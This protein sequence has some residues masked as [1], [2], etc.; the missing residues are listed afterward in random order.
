MSISLYNY[1]IIVPL[2]I[3]GL[4]STA[5]CSND[6]IDPSKA[7]GGRPKMMRAEG[8]VV[9]PQV[10]RQQ[11]TASG[12][13]LP[14]E[15]VALHPEISGRVTAI[16]FREGSQ[17]RKGQLL[18]QLYDAD[19]KAQIQKLRAQRALQA[20]TLQR[21]DELLQ[22]G[23]ISRQDYETTQ[24]QIAAIDADIA[25]QEA[26]LRKTRITAPFDG[27]IGIRGISTGAV[28]SPADVVA[29]LQQINPLKMDFTIP[30]QYRSYLERGMTVNFA[31]DGRLDTLS[32]RISAIEP[33]ADASTRTIR[34]RALVQNPGNKLV[35]GAFAHV[36]IPFQSSTDAI[37]IP[38]QSVIPT[39]REKKVAVLRQGKAKMAVVTLGNR[40]ANSVQVLDGLQAGDTILTTG[41]MQVKDGMDITVTKVSTGG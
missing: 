16:H 35:A 31:V 32:G 24:T 8:F 26:Q 34:A 18:V 15:Q 40:T 12:S 7:A 4:L 22:I 19:I 21:Q 37:L 28:I 25:F 2:A 5:G 33:G 3:L 13:L 29:S 41:L 38:S 17:V 6:K 10:F 14:N 23:G 27:I 39:T 9:K 36:T 1:K 20:R 30:D 11:Y